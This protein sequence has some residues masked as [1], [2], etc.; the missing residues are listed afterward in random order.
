M[1]SDNNLQKLAANAILPSYVSTLKHGA[2][3]QKNEIL[4]TDSQP[5]ETTVALSVTGQGS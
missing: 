5:H 4:N 2:D 1:A 3:S